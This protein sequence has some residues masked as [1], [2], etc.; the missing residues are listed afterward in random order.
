VS[1][2]AYTWFPPKLAYDDGR[3]IVYGDYT[4]LLFR[5]LTR[6][7]NKP[8]LS[9]L[10]GPSG[11]NMLEDAPVDHL[12][13][14]GV[15]WGHGDVN[16]VDYY[17][18]LPGGEGPVDRGRIEH[19]GWS[20]VIDE[21]PRFGFVERLVW[22]DHHDQSTIDERRSVVVTFGSDDHYTVDLQSCYRAERDLVFG[23]TKE[24]VLPGIRIAEA[25][26]GLGGGAIVNSRGQCGE[27][28]TFGQ[29]AE[30]VDVS[31]PRTVQY[32]GG[33]VV[34]GIACFD[35]PSNPGHPQRWFTREYGPVSPFEGHHFHDDRRL[36]GG[37]ELSLRHRIVIH[38]G[39]AA[40]AGLDS[41]FRS[42]C[43]EV[44]DV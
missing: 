26:T 20:K 12:H 38:T 37:A 35:H 34:E 18:E 8:Y 22:R 41:L 19:L 6:T 44:F 14:H 5:Y 42:Y 36:A 2:P 30:W 16:G 17:L 9:T 28:A 21:A 10:C 24:S 15:W 43:E 40:E 32:V 4:M 23:D 25:L 27:A 33:T 13:H 3:F 1:N 11:R 39:T 7:V 31:G 29:P